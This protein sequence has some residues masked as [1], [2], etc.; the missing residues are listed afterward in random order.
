MY[1]LSLISSSIVSKQPNYK[2]RLGT[3]KTHLCTTNRCVPHVTPWRSP[4]GRADGGWRG[5]T[6]GLTSPCP[7]H[8]RCRASYSN[9]GGPEGAL[10]KK[11][12]TT[13]VLLLLAKDVLLTWGSAAVCGTH[14]VCSSSSYNSILFWNGSE[15]VSQPYIHP[16]SLKKLG[17]KSN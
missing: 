8:G 5:H 15:P 11:L 12:C 6:G 17:L 2:S 13:T 1:K 3:T 10:T 7:W 14:M 4:V 16:S 9:T